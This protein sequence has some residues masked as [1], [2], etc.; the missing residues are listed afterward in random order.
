MTRTIPVEVIESTI[1]TLKRH[2]DILQRAVEESRTAYSTVDDEDEMEG[3]RVDRL[4]GQALYEI[5]EGTILEVRLEG[6]YDPWI[7][8]LV[9]Q[10]C[11]IVDLGGLP[12][13]PGG[14]FHV[15]ANAVSSAS[16]GDALLDAITIA[17]EQLRASLRVAP[18]GAPERSGEG[19]RMGFPSY[20]TARDRHLT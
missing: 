9:N 6:A 13:L 10:S 8:S 16:A 17:L 12:G 11:A 19:W 20:D 1:M 15:N 14:I 3:E 5:W 18:D 7:V 4:V 2:A